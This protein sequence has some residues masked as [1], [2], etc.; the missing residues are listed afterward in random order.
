MILKKANAVLGILSSFAV[1]VHMGYN[2]FSY[3]TFYYNPG[4]KLATSIPLMVLVC[5]HA[6]CGMCSVFLQA[7]GT[8]TFQYPAQNKRIIIQRIS[9]ALIFP[10]LFLHIKTF[11]L[12]RSC[13][14][15]GLWLVFGLLMVVQIFFYVVIA[16]HTM[17]SFSRACITLGMIDDERKV[18]IVDMIVWC[19]MGAALIATSVSVIRGQLIMFIPR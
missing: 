16:L 3:L 6:V 17:V 7:D 9:A 2:C 1:L 13:A 11:D 10:L 8:N 18:K 15:N 14:D 5:A 19:V 4:L 12:L